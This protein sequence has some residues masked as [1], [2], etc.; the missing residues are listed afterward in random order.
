MFA[1]AVT[2]SGESVFVIDKFEF[3][4]SVVV[5]VSLL[6]LLLGSVVADEVVTVFVKTVP[7][8]RASSMWTVSVNT[9]LPG[10]NDEFEQETVPPEPTGGVVQDHPPGDERA[11]NVS[12]PG[13]RSENAAV[14][15]L[16]G[17]A[18]ETVIV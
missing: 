7:F 18:F 3:R 10:A 9:A 15:E 13:R 14:V 16:D 11:T 8:A 4:T 1:P 6:L 5:S 17:P 12:P 2:G